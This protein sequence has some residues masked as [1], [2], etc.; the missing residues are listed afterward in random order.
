MDN[1]YR[2]VLAKEKNHTSNEGGSHD[3]RLSQA[4][5]LTVK[6]KNKNKNNSEI[7]LHQNKFLLL[8]MF[9]MTLFSM[10]QSTCYTRLSSVDC[11]G[12]LNPFVSFRNHQ[13][14]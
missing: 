1:K 3:R 13:N 7:R 4:G 8:W 9:C 12:F 11:L 10:P 6:R 2:H 5:K 14:S